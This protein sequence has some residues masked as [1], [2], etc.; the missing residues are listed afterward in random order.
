MY[1]KHLSMLFVATAMT[2]GG[3]A[4]SAADEPV[5][6]RQALVDADYAQGRAVFQQRCSACHSVAEGGM[7]LSG[8]NL[9]G[10]F[11]R[12]IGEKPDFS[13]SEALQKADFEWSAGKLAAWL[14]DPQGYLPGNMMGLPEAVPQD[15]LVPLLSYLMLETGAAD[16]PKPEAAAVAESGGERGRAGG[17]VAERFPAF[18]KHLMTN[19][20]R[21]TL[22][23]GTDELKF[24]VYF[25]E[26][27]SAESNNEQ[28]KGFWHVDERDSFCYALYG[29][30]V[31]PLQFVE[32]FPI[33][34]MSIPRFR[35]ELWKS[36]PLPGIQLTG[37]I[38]AGRPLGS[39]ADAGYWKN[40][41]ENTMRYEIVVDGEKR[42]IDAWFNQDK[43]I[44]SNVAGVTG[45]WVIEGGQAEEAMCYALTGIDGVEGE[46]AECFPLRLMYDPR[47][48]ARWPS[49]FKNGMAYWCEVVAGR[50]G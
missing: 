7:D 35:E 2:M 41:F 22:R 10:M 5:I 3:M 49:K 25:Q 38:V 33:V 32:C 21:Y 12:K 1:R 8:P 15:D 24:D 17:D 47:I 43:T 19:T 29:L 9:Y 26:D 4:A 18:W 45:T 11:A 34:A 20:T 39:D 6:E 46:L 48:G 31:K 44:T 42:V 27:G 16:W 28:I 30:P 23:N 14:D 40:L 13:Y 36:E 50:S 37:G